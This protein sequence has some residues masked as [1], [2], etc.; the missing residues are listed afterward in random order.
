MHAASV[1]TK[2]KRSRDSALSTRSGRA[3]DDV[4]TTPYQSKVYTDTPATRSP[5]LTV[6]LAIIILGLLT[7]GALAALHWFQRRAASV[8][9]ISDS[10]FAMM[11]RTEAQGSTAV[12]A[13]LESRKSDYLALQ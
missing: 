4:V 2:R 11:Q 10:T 9:Q 8:S 7:L 13:H 12:S 1:T 3:E 5:V 6:V